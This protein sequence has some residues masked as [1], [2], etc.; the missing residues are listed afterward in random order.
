[1]ATVTVSSAENALKSYYLDAI[2]EELDNKIS[3]FLAA[4]EKTSNDVYGKEVV[5]VIQTGLNGGVGVGDEDGNLPRANGNRYMKFT[6]PLK[7]IYGTIQISDKAL[8]ASSNNSMLS[9]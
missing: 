7:N 3:P 5:R 8:R 2:K 4:I 1:M 6:A 9:G